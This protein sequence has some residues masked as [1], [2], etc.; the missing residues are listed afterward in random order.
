MREGEEKYV[1][2]YGTKRNNRKEIVYEKFT[3]K[4]FNKWILIFGMNGTFF[5]GDSGFSICIE[6]TC[7]YLQLVMNRNEEIESQH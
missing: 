2:E 4:K 1:N 7:T 5:S 6:S 3:K